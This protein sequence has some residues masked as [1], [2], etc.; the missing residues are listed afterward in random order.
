MKDP[1]K[2]D[3]TKPVQLSQI[4]CF[5][6]AFPRMAGITHA[7]YAALRLHGKKAFPARSTLAKALAISKESARDALAALVEAELVREEKREG[8]STAYHLLDWPED[9]IERIGI[10]LDVEK[11]SNFNRYQVQS[12]V[13]GD[14]RTHTLLT[15]GQDRWDCYRRARSRWDV[16]D[17]LLKAI[18]LSDVL[19]EWKNGS[20]DDYRGLTQEFTPYLMLKV[21]RRLEGWEEEDINSTTGG[22]V[23]TILTSLVLQEDDATEGKWS[24]TDYEKGLKERIEHRTLGYARVKRERADARAVLL[25]RKA[26]TEAAEKEMEEADAT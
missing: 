19:Q 6:L 18:R 15:R 23:R 13:P 20:P 14:K 2:K 25:R 12:L 10:A 17:D 4:Q 9:A 11:R 21:A 5:L 1:T 16:E 22:Y 8:Q 3:L 26:A 24:L 7:V